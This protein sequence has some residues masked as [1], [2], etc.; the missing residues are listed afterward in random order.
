MYTASK[1]LA[2]TQQFRPVLQ[3][4]DDTIFVLLTAEFFHR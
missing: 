3:A 2:V 1:S 4:G